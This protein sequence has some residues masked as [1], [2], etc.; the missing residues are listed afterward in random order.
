MDDT[1]ASLGDLGGTFTTADGRFELFVSRGITPSSRAIVRVPHEEGTLLAPLTRTT[2]LRVDTTSTAVQTLVFWITETDGGRSLSDFEVAEL[3][4]LLD[5]A[6]QVIASSGLDITDGEAVLNRVLAELGGLF[7]Q[8]AGGTPDVQ[9]GFLLPD[10]QLNSTP[11]SG[12]TDLVSGNGFTF[13]LRTNGTAEDGFKVGGP[14]DA[15]DG[16][17]TL[18]VGG[19]TFPNSSA[20]VEDGNM[21][22][23]GPTPLGALQVTRRIFVDPSSPFARFTEVLENPTGASIT[24]KVRISGNLGSDSNTQELQSGTG[25]RV[26]GGQISDPANLFWFGNA[27]WSRS[28]DSVQWEYDVTVPAAG[29]AT[30]IHFAAMAP[31]PASDPSYGALLES[32]PPTTVDG[33]RNLAQEDYE[34][35]A[36]FTPQSGKRIFGPAGTHAPLSEVTVTNLATHAS[37]TTQVARDGSWQVAIPYERGEELSVT[38]T[39]GNNFTV[40]AP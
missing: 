25:W 35:N 7:A 15:Y 36:S 26:L 13:D 16:M 10:L 18:T 6:R 12:R 11:T 3:S 8:Y 4:S 29:R 14:A 31:Q 24:T 39:D 34:V 9:D 37:R 40:T 33:L 32:L 5:Q 20:A 38:G 17:F 23:V 22:V 21:L 28:T 30:V 27:S 2:D 1:G 19:V